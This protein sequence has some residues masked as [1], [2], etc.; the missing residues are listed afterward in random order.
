MR[1]LDL[2]RDMS[3]VIPTGMGPDSAFLF[4]RMEQ[5]TFE[6]I[7]LRRG[8]RVVDVASGVGQ[9]DHALAEAGLWVAGAEPSARMMELARGADAERPDTTRAN[10]VRLRAWSEALPFRDGEFDG[11]FCKGS[12][13]HFDDPSS[14]V[15]EMARVTR[16][17]GRVVIAIAN[18]ESIGCRLARWLD[19]RSGADATPGR[20]LYDVPSDHFT[21]YDA[22]LIRE[23]LEPYFSI[24]REV[25]VSLFW[26]VR[27]WGRFLARLGPLARPILLACDAVARAFPSWADVIVVAGPP[28]SPTQDGTRGASAQSP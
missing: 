13:D 1:L 23:Q 8:K 19:R 6:A 11:A 4:Q 25:G 7:G 12:L 14:A 9:D 16:A 21:R 15:R 22:A 5:A 2:D 17:D 28:R 18:F 3:D 27:R 26:G 10:V 24:E 20:R